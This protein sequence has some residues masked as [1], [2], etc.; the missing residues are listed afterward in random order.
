MDLH[1][2]FV[3]RPSHDDIHVTSA[4][5]TDS[6]TGVA[7]VDGTVTLYSSTTLDKQAVLARNGAGPARICRFSPDSKIVVVGYDSQ[8]M[9]VTNVKDCFNEQFL[10]V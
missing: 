8:F 5:A 4:D 9:E 6:V 7:S 3:L 10:G 1:T 2:F